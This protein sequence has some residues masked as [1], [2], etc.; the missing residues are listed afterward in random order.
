MRFYVSWQ[1]VGFGCDFTNH[2][3]ILCIRTYRA[4]DFGWCSTD[5]GTQDRSTFMGFFYVLGAIHK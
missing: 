1:T 2:V 4:V 3:E 5:H